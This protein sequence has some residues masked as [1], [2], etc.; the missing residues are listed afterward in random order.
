MCEAEVD[1]VV[2]QTVKR[3]AKQIAGFEMYG[4]Q[5]EGLHCN[6]CDI[7]SLI[8]GEYENI[9]FTHGVDSVVDMIK[10]FSGFDHRNLKLCME[11]LRKGPGLKGSCYIEHF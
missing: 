3:G 11:V 8:A 1:T 7:V 4:Q 2:A 6:L 10:T 9:A 5:I